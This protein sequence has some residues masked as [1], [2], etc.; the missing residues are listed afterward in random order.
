MATASEESGVTQGSSEQLQR[1][2]RYLM[3][4]A[5]ILDCVSRH[6][7]GQDRHDMQMLT[8]AYHPDGYDEHGNVVNEAKNYATWVNGLHDA[9]FRIH[10]H[11]ITT[12]NCEIAGDVAH[13]ESYVLYGLLGKDEKDV[14][15]GGGRYVDRLE[16]RD[17]VWKIALRRT[18][19]DW[20]FKAD[21]SPLKTQYFLDQGYPQGSDHRTDISYQRPLQLG[22]ECAP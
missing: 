17:G 14:W 22:R 9:T 19:I 12:H 5:A 10:S 11:N 6:S 20:M 21:A 2:V 3:D 16:R 4:R 8:S 13:A 15:F 7:R 18:L 1:D